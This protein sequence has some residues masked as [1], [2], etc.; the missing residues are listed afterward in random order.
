MRVVQHVKLCAWWHMDAGNLHTAGLLR[1][2]TELLQTPAKQ[3]HSELAA[4]VFGHGNS[5]GSS[6]IDLVVM[7]MTR[8]TIMAVPMSRIVLRNPFL[9]VAMLVTFPDID[10]YACMQ[11]LLGSYR[12]SLLKH[13]G[14]VL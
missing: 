5:H 11:L 9:P 7:I 8:T 10:L 3:M 4:V 6:H 14:Q 1:E 12:L 2:M 13:T